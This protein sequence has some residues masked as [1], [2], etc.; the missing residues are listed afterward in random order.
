MTKRVKLISIIFAT[1][2][3]FPIIVVLIAYLS[4]IRVFVVQPIGAVPDGRT[5]IV[6]GVSRLH[7]VDSPDAICDRIGS[8]N[9]LCRGSVIAG[10]VKNGKILLRLPYSQFLYNL[11]GAPETER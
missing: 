5:I 1:V 7:A 3:I 2:I 11:S 4:G 9:L 6:S 10:V 8:V